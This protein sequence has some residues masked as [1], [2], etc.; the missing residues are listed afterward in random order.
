[1]EM[2][3]W[4]K[5]TCNLMVLR[6]YYTRHKRMWSQPCGKCV[7]DFPTRLLQLLDAWYHTTQSGQTTESAELGRETHSRNVQV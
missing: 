7:C 5:I 1:M 3:I 6:L 2:M 4:C